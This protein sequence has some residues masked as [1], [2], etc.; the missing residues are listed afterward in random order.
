MYTYIYIYIYWLVVSNPLK[1]IYNL[2]ENKTCSKPPNSIMI[3]IWQ[4]VPAPWCE[5]QRA[6]RV[7]G[8]L[9]LGWFLWMVWFLSGWWYTS[10]SEKQQSCG[11]FIPNIW[12]SKKG[13]Q[14][15]NQYQY[16]KCIA[17]LVTH[18]RSQQYCSR[19][20]PAAWKLLQYDQYGQSY[21]II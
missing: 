2:R 5:T 21:N 14:R 7:D 20:F 13:F 17:I 4:P 15:T 8:W 12:R 16:G 9:I 18:N 6:W 11:I 1:N 19:D 3:S 10:H